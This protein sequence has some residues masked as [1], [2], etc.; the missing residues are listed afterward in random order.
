MKAAWYERFGQAQDVLETGDRPM[1]VAGP[2][3]VLI[4]L[5]TSGVN[6]SD[7]KKRTGSIP[8]LLSQGY[9]IPHSDGAGVIE[10]VGTGV[11]QA[12][13]GHIV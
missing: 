3:E 12:R 1:P 6:P 11:Q 13:V 9:V 8:D 2:G 4:R 10:S 7:V 5:K